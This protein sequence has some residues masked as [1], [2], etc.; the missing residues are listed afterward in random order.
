MKESDYQ[1]CI[2][3]INALHTH[4]NNIEEKQHDLIA[5]NQRL[6]EVIRLAEAEI[7]KRRSQTQEMETEITALQR[8][9]NEAK[10]RVEN[11]IERLD[12]MMESTT[13]S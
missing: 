10:V 5:E 6:R 3:K 1:S 7:A 9:K 8:D 11:A 13:E 12:N 4:L 2:E